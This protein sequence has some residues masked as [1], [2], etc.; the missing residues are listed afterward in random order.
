[1]QG[2]SES[3]QFWDSREDVEIHERAKLLIKPSKKSN[4]TCFVA[5]WVHNPPNHCWGE[6]RTVYSGRSEAGVV[7]ASKSGLINFDSQS[8]LTSLL[9][10]RF[11]DPHHAARHRIRT[12]LVQNK[13]NELALFEAA[14]P[15]YLETILR[16]IEDE[17]WN[18]L[19]LAPVLD[20]QTGALFE[21][22]SL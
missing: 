12:V 18:P 22:S 14:G 4:E 9:R 20:D 2:D 1:V 15:Y 10:P 21:R 8:S 11:A 19:R 16:V 17:A 7:M 5:V 13:F 6:H 3:A